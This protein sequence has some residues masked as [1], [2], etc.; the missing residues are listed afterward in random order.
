[1]WNVFENA[2]RQENIL[3][4]LEDNPFSSWDSSVSEEDTD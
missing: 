4:I 1:M 2:W 3:S